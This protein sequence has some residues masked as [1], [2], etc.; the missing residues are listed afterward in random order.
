MKQSN[1]ILIVIVMCLLILLGCSP[2]GGSDSPAEKDLFSYWESTDGVWKIELRGTDFGQTTIFPISLTGGD[3]CNCL[4]RFTGVQSN[5]FFTMNNC[6]YQ[7][8]S[9]SGLINCSD[10][11]QTGTYTKTSDTLSLCT[12]MI[13][14]SQFC[15]TYK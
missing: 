13:D 1:A 11:N 7:I 10:F 2:D 5:G 15:R 14:G 12:N 8:G 9:G 4:Q 6:T 3:Q